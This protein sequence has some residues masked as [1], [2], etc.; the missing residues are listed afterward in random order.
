MTPTSSATDVLAVLDSLK[1]DKPVLIGRSFGGAELSSIGSRRP[2]RVAGLVY[3]D[4]AWNYA[5][6]D[7][8]KGDLLGELADVLRKI[9]L[10]QSGP[11]ANY[12]EYVAL[13]RQL[14]D[15]A[16]PR[17]ERALRDVGRM[18]DSSA[19]RTSL[20]WPQPPS[21]LRKL[22]AGIRMYMHIDAPVLAIYAAPHRELPPDARVN[23]SL[24]VA[25][26]AESFQRVVPTAKV[27]LL[28]NAEPLIWLSNGDDVF[29][30]RHF[31]A[32]RAVR[33]RTLYEHVARQLGHADVQ[34]V[35]RVYG[36]HAPS[37]DEQNGNRAGYLTSE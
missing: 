19:S 1:L 7:P 33:A 18:V 15:T 4:A 28:V 23:D 29:I 32:I 36:R 24:L 11:F 31:Y 27:M 25:Q 34:M 3:L 14:A 5:F 9:A 6:Y 2:S 17:L 22:Q 10:F 8:A 12:K 20:P 16:L 30:A 35:A 37:S 13:T 26:V 21:T